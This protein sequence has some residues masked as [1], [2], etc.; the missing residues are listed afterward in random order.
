LGFA[1]SGATDAFEPEVPTG[2]SQVTLGTLIDLFNATDANGTAL[3]VE[4][5]IA[6]GGLVLS[7]REGGISL[8][9]LRIDK[10]PS[11]NVGTTDGE[12]FVSGSAPE[13]AEFLSS[14]SVE[15][16]VITLTSADNVKQQFTVT[17]ATASDPAKPEITEV[18]FSTTDTDYFAT[19]ID[20][21]GSKGQVSITVGA[22]SKGEGGQTF[23]VD[24]VDGDALATVEALLAKMQDET[25]GL[26]S[27]V[28]SVDWDLSFGEA[29]GASV[30]LAADYGTGEGGIV[31]A[32]FDT[33]GTADFATYLGQYGSFTV[34]DLTVQEGEG[35]GS[36]TFSTEKVYV[37]LE[38]WAA[39]AQA[40][41]QE[42]IDASVTVSINEDSEGAF[43]TLAVSADIA[44]QGNGSFALDFAE[45][46]LTGA[47]FVIEGTEDNVDLN[48]SASASKD[49]VKQVT[50][51]EFR[52]AFD[53]GDFVSGIGREVSVTVANE[54]F[55]IDGSTRVELLQ[56]LEAKLKAAIADTEG[57]NLSEVLSADGI[58]IEEGEGGAAPS[59]TLTARYG[60]V[61]P[62]SVSGFKRA[63]FDPD[64]EGNVAQEVRLTFGN[65][66]L[67]NV[68]E[69]RVLTLSLGN[70]EVSYTVG[71]GDT[72]VAI[73]QALATA[74]VNADSTL[75]DL[76][77]PDDLSIDV[78]AGFPGPDLLGTVESGRDNTISLTEADADGGNA[79][80][81]TAGFFAD[82]TTEGAIVLGDLTATPP[83][84]ET[85]ATASS[86][87]AGVNFVS[88][89]AS[90]V[91]TETTQEAKDQT[92]E[93]VGYTNPGTGEG[94]DATFFGDAD[95]Q[96]IDPPLP[97]AGDYT[98]A[99]LDAATTTTGTGKPFGN[100]LVRND[101]T[102]DGVI[103]HAFDFSVFK[104]TSFEITDTSDATQVMRA[105]ERSL[106]LDTITDLDTTVAG[107]DGS[108]PIQNGG[109]KQ[110]LFLITDS[111]TGTSY[112]W[113]AK[114]DD[115]GVFKPSNAAL[116]QTFSG[117]AP[118]SAADF[119]GGVTQTHTNPDNGYTAID[120]S[121]QFDGE[122]SGEGDST[123]FGDAA[124]DGAEASAFG[125]SG[126]V[127]TYT[128]P[129][130]GYSAID[131]SPVFD[132][133]DT[134][135]GDGALFGSEPGYYDDEG[136]W[137]SYLNGGTLADPAGE[138]DEGN[139]L[140]SQ[141]DGEDL[142]PLNIGDGSG[143]DDGGVAGEDAGSAD[144]AG[145]DID[146]VDGFAPFDWDES[147]LTIL[148]D[149]S[150]GADVINNFQVDHDLIALEGE[151][152]ESTLDGV[153][154]A[155]LAD[156]VAVPVSVGSSAVSAGSDLVT[157]GPTLVF[158]WDQDYDGGR[159]EITGGEFLRFYTGIYGTADQG[160]ALN[161]FNFGAVDAS[162]DLVNLSFDNLEDF[163]AALNSTQDQGQDAI[164]IVGTIVDGN[165]VLS[166]NE[167]YDS[168]NTGG[169]WRVY[170]EQIDIEIDGIIRTNFDLSTTEFGLVDS[171]SSTL[172]SVDLSDADEV[173][174]LLNSV[175]DFDAMQ[176][177]PRGGL[178]PSEDPM[179]ID[180]DGGGSGEINTTI[181]A[182]TASD[183]DSV[184]AIWAHTQSASDDN[185]VEA[186]E[187]ALLT[188]V[189]TTGGEFSSDNFAIWDGT[190]FEQP[191]LQPQAPF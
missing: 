119:T 164:D 76:A 133:E 46:E 63:S 18:S 93:G 1:A 156:P 13:G 81:V 170:S 14:V 102:T 116:V 15:N 32:L 66:F 97:S 162:T 96:T 91:K 121:P 183:D 158:D 88:D 51:V 185:T 131:A 80:E 148:S 152:A 181:F 172:S 19:A 95:Q 24:M 174:D 82:Q 118:S 84:T 147:D 55:T 146:G 3:P 94:A 132:G 28:A 8:V 30:E 168:E 176:M 59:M 166:L 115:L 67:S 126:V 89:D 83:E 78:V 75:V 107:A 143:E 151:L 38:D 34:R 71:S 86:E 100:T 57:S 178:L 99:E 98:F 167:P 12:G 101:L 42:E 26:D 189:N 77:V 106:S 117:F 79:V 127:Q 43:I 109:S 36:A 39:D 65:S 54:T 180:L 35:A 173:A 111:G 74:L 53:D 163:V 52:D 40:Y 49:A 110:F 4:L 130:N 37:R 25:A 16:G 144:L 85:V 179:Q 186:E 120:N 73:V 58:S 6:D 165:L 142:D 190:S 64:G 136:L 21:T 87:T 2:L 112:L 7:G 11:S 56:D 17:G 45:R 135:T 139:D 184:T 20:E 10:D 103:T 22:D 145:E 29:S 105:F 9:G 124:I 60:E 169:S 41:F 154:D 69:G 114:V 149:V 72:A 122:D 155:V 5:S 61:D 138:D 141:L 171:A 188:M 191:I 187:L 48:I 128:N 104:G 108:F 68:A 44:L 23:T 123:F 47:K 175:F 92:E 113:S 160:I 150:T 153:V 161:R 125:P 137:T 134:E 182:V 33:Q 157:G 140:Y 177:K 129:D 31:G 70:V 62:L 90:A 159:I 50:K 27:T